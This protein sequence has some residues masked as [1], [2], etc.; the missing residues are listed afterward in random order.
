MLAAHARHVGVDDLHAAEG[1]AE[2]ERGG[3][4]HA[5]S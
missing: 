4:R 2:G 1:R 3:L 5:G